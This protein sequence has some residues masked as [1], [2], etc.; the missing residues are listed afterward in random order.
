VTGRTVTSVSVLVPTF[1]RCSSVRRLLEALARQTLPPSA[2]EVVVSVDGSTDGTSEMLRVFQADYQLRWSSGPNRGR[3]AACNDAIRLAEGALVVLLDD[4]M[5]PEPGL[6]AAHLREHPAGSRRCV[7]GAVPIAERPTDPPHVRYA[8]RK[9]NEHLERLAEPGHRFVLR[10][11][12]SG[13]TSVARDELLAVGLYDED[14]Q[15]YGNE[16]LELSHRLV[17]NGV[18][19]GFSPQARAA[20]HYEKSLERLIHD[21]IEKGRTAMLFIAKHPEAAGYLK[22]EALRRQPAR[23]RALRHLAVLAVHR[24]DSAPRVLAIVLD[25]FARIGLP[26]S[27]RIYRATL[28]FCY[29]LGVERADRGMQPAIRR[30]VR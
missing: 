16:D 26:R 15:S 8:A 4:D 20:Q 1:Q 22:L 12:Y 3:A 23:Q 25:A 5:E 2:F 17:R 11:F 29:M 6:L 28:D 7:M 30:G 9:F 18:R 13:N 24:W 21:E 19:L 10:D 14:F 27:D